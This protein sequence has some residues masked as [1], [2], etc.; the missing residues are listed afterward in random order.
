MRKFFFASAVTLG[1]VLLSS[2]SAID[3]VTGVTLDSERVEIEIESGILDQLDT[4]VTAE[5]PDPLVGQVG[6][7]RTC[8]IEDEYGTT[9]LVDVT[10]QNSEG[11]IVWKV[12][13]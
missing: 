2:C 12:Q 11:D 13:D 8:S 3:S 5:C 9:A 7:T 6:D 10:I 1:L 4:N